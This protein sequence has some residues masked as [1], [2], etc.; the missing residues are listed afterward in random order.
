MFATFIPVLFYIYDR[1]TTSLWIRYPAILLGEGYNWHM[2]ALQ[3]IMWL[4]NNNTMA[5]QPGDL[6]GRLDIVAN[7]LPAPPMTSFAA[8]KAF[9]KSVEVTSAHDTSLVGDA[10]LKGGIILVAVVVDKVLKGSI[11]REEMSKALEEK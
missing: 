8:S 3:I 5:G 11:A 2:Y 1:I 6:V 7:G 10:S 9:S 4:R